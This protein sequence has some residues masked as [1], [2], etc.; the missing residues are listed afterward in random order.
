MHDSF[1]LAGKVPI[2][3]PNCI[4]TLHITPMIGL[5]FRP[6]CIDPFG[7]T[8]SGNLLW[9]TKSKG[10]DLISIVFHVF[11]LRLV[12]KGLETM[13][14]RMWIGLHQLDTSQGWQWS[15]GSPLS[16]LRWQPGNRTLCGFS[17]LASV[18]HSD[19]CFLSYLLL[20]TALS[21][22]GCLHV[23]R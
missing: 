23:Q 9:I 12:L 8:S 3:P 2:I 7:T 19:C 1:G 14:E 17:V 18:F 10:T 13:P 6:H 4:D 15:D 5:R 21:H 11:L 16:Y 22:P 20:W